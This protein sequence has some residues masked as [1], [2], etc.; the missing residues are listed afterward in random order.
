MVRRAWVRYRGTLVAA[1]IFLV[2]AV[3]VGVW[4]RLAGAERRGLSQ[5]PAAERAALYQE[6]RRN[7]KALCDK[8][9]TEP[10]L[11]ARCRESAEFLM[12]FPECDDDCAAFA[13][14]YVSQPAR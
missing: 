14:N 4:I 8:A 13:R 3:L 12:L 7:T 11:D 10:W 9:R 2:I 1:A 6:T 5:M